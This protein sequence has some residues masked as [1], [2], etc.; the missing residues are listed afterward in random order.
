VGKELE[1]IETVLKEGRG[2]SFLPRV[3]REGKRGLSGRDSRLAGDWRE[4]ARQ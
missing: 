4:R 1:L 2:S 3:T